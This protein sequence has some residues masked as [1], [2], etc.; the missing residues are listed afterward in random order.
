MATDLV[1]K[2]INLPPKLW[3]RI[4]AYKEDF[5]IPE[6]GEAI[7]RLIVRSIKDWEA[8]QDEGEESEA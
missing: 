4:Q 7:R 3:A 8:D 6:D 1:R 5:F 2:T